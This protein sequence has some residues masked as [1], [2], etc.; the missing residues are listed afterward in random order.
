VNDVINK[1]AP[2]GAC[3]KSQAEY[4][5]RSCLINSTMLPYNGIGWRFNC[6]FSHNGGRIISSDACQDFGFFSPPESDDW[7]NSRAIRHVAR[8][9][10]ASTVSSPTPLLKLNDPD[11]SIWLSVRSSDYTSTA[12]NEGYVWCGWKTSAGQM[13]GAI[14]RYEQSKNYFIPSNAISRN[15]VTGQPPEVRR[16]SE[17]NPI[18]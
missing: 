1:W 8:G 12:I 13:W 2:Y 14:W 18:G 5:L 15:F 11:N 6:Y 3:E 4:Y 9:L 17:T 7:G 16:V 10:F